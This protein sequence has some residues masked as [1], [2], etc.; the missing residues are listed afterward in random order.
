PNLVPSPAKMLAYPQPFHSDIRIGGVVISGMDVLTAVL[1]PVLVI[2]LALFM[3]YSMLGK[4]IRAAATNP[5][6]A[7]LC[8]ISVSRVSA[9]TWGMAGAFAAV[10]AVTQAPTQPTF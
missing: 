1:V 6:S 5:D 3:R 9:L 8:G 7:R 10:S 2:G 4:E